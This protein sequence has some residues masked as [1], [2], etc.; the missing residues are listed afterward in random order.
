MTTPLAHIRFT[1][2]EFEAASLRAKHPKPRE[3]FER[4]LATSK[5]LYLPNPQRQGCKTA[6]SRLPCRQ[7]VVQLSF[8]LASHNGWNVFKF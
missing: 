4:K 2:R 5:Q 6:V 3:Q 8:A 1:L 7:L